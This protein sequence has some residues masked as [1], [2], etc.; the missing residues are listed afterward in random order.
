MGNACS[1]KKKKKNEIIAPATKK[2]TQ[3][4]YQNKKLKKKSKKQQI[5]VEKDRKIIQKEKEL[6]QVI[7]DAEGFSVHDLALLGQKTSPESIFRQDLKPR[8]MGR[9]KLIEDLTPHLTPTSSRTPG[10][11]SKTN[12][13]QTAEESASKEEFEVDEVLD[14]VD[15]LYLQLCE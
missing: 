13:N 11:S 10:K 3:M 7:F 6:Y 14:Y 5:I 4:N 12:K 1:C 15:D 8:R 2:P 9:V